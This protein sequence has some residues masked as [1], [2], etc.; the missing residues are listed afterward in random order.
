[1]R[2]ALWSG[3]WFRIMLSLIVLGAIFSSPICVLS[4]LLEGPRDPAP[5]DFLRRNFATHS[6][7][8]PGSPWEIRRVR[9]LGSLEDRD[10]EIFLEAL[11]RTPISPTFSVQAQPEW[12]PIPSHSI[13]L[14]ATAPLRC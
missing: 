2:A 14:Q 5:P 7:Q 13:S 11:L 1:M 9:F 3:R 4:P 8:H 10:H 6:K 12:L